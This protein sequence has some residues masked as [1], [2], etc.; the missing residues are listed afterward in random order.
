MSAAANDMLVETIA[1]K[2]AR[3]VRAPWFDSR[4]DAALTAFR[5]HGVPHRR[6]EEWKYS[7]LRAALEARTAVGKIASPKNSFAGIA[8][9]R[10]DFVDGKLVTATDA[11]PA[12]VEAFDFSNL[13]TAPEWVRRHLGKTGADGM[14]AASLALM[15]GGIALHVASGVTVEEPVHLNFTSANPHHARVL[16]AMEDRASLTLI[17]SHANA[18][19]L[20]NLGVEIVLGE[21][22]ELTHV[23]LAEGAA[24]AVQVQEMAVSAAAGSQYRA[25]FA[26]LG[27]KLSRLEIGIALAG[28]GAEANL[29]GVSV[30]SDGRHADVTTRIDHVA[31]HTQSVQ[32]FKNAA[33]G[34]SRAV[35]QGKISVHEGADG[36]DSRQTAKALLLG[37]HAEAD[38]KPELEILADDVKCAHGA[39]VGDLDSEALFYLRA[40]G[41]PETEARGLLIRAFLED[42]VDEIE[43]ES[44][45]AAVWRAVEAAL[46]Q[47]TG[48][49]P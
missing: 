2:A 8:G 16:I 21:N 32:L 29:S 27:A 22:A 48:A 6:V 15:E 13:K 19:A 25:H 46:V 24:E 30:V 1:G 45:R 39:A 40:R 20:A 33:G 41:I 42:A 7:D 43:N 5:A 47:A 26:D 9:T 11:A 49:Q 36:S 3:V 35:Y 37:S 38:L 4:R 28:E 10:F 44:I 18:S 14:A 12:T 23:R 17:E 34:K 31:G